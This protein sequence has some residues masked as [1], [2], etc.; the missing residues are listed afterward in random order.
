[1]VISRSRIDELLDA[2]YGMDNGLEKLDMREAMKVARA[3]HEIAYDIET[4]G[5]QRARR[6]IAKVRSSK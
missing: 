4:L 1:M 5:Y 6:D 2:Y 3:L